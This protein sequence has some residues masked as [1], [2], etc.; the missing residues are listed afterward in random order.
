ME[1]SNSTFTHSYAEFGGA[2]LQLE[3][4]LT[5][6][7]CNFTQN[8]AFYD[9]GAIYASYVNLKLNN[10]NFADNRGLNDDA[11][12]SNGGGLYLDMTNAT[13]TNSSFTNN[14]AAFDGGAIYTYDTSLFMNKNYFTN[15]SQFNTTG[16]FSAFDKNYTALNCNFTDDIISLNN[17]IYATIVDGSGITLTL[18]NNTITL[19]KLPS[20]FDL[21]DFG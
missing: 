5:V 4:S 1:I 18:V 2:I 14:F 19:T 11:R 8:T 20:R 7:N 9:G 17:T 10:D 21:R 6:E 12:G 13:I 15:N 16:I 3:G